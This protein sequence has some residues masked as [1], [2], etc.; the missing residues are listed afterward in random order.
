M[1]LVVFDLDGTLV[2]SFAD[3]AAAVN[4]V[5]A[6]LERPALST[7]RVRRSVGRGLENLLRELLPGDLHP[8]LPRAVAEMKSFYLEHPTDSSTLYPGVK[9]VLDTLG[10]LG[11]RR[12]VLSNK[13]DPVVA[14]I[15]EDLGLSERLDLALGHRETAPLKPDP[16][17]LFEILERLGTVPAECLMVGDGLPD[18]EIAQAAGTA[19][20]AVSYGIVPRERWESLGVVRIVDTLPELL[21]GIITSG[22][23]LGLPWFKSSLPLVENQMRED[24][25]L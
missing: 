15:C 3:I 25:A 10:H 22:S 18:W 14:R 13:A 19:F 1:K 6:L 17:P 2:D 11:I 16:R 7:E 4:H 8:E 20:C 5:L 9:Q 23:E 24:I 21:D 12:A